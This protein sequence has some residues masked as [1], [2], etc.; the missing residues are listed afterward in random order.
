MLEWDQLDKGAAV[1]VPLW[2]D[3]WDDEAVLDDDFAIQLR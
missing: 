1:S 2:Q 3:N